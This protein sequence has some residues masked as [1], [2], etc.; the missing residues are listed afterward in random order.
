MSSNEASW[1]TEVQ[2]SSFRGLL[3]GVDMSRKVPI[4]G[5]L[6]QFR[7]IIEPEQS[8]DAV[9]LPV[10]MALEDDQVGRLDEI[11]RLR[12]FNSIRLGFRLAE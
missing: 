10:A 9:L 11:A 5:P 6:I 8:E 4:F 2:T 1:K 3:F 12:C 7:G